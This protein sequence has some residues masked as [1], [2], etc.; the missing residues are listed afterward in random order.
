M[1]DGV[2]LSGEVNAWA[3]SGAGVD[4]AGASDESV[5]VH[6]FSIGGFIAGSP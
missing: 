6:S 5:I 4:F 3:T 1:V 2:E